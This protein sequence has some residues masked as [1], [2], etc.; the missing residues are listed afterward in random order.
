MRVRYVSPWYPDYAAIHSGVFVAK[1]VE[2]V[3]QAGHEVTVQVPQIFPAPS[4]PIPQPVIDA[5]RTLAGDSLDAMFSSQN[6]VTYVPSPV[7]SRG[8]PLGRA[9]AVADSLS[10][11]AEFVGD[12]PDVIHAHVGLPTGLAVSQVETDRPL[13][14]TEHWSGLASALD[15]PTVASAYADLLKRADA[16]ICVSNHL[17]DQICEA[18]G[19]WAGDQIEVIPNIVDLADITFRSRPNVDFGSW[20]Y[21]GGLMQHKGV[22][23][24]VRAFDRYSKQFDSDARLTL[25]GD[26]PM[27]DWIEMYAISHGLS[28]SIALTGSV[29]HSALGTHLD[30]ADVMVHLSP[31]ETFGIASLEGIGAGLPVVSLRNQGA[32]GA[33]G[34]LEEQ[35]GSLLDLESTPTDVAEAIAALKESPD[36][37][38]IAAGRKMIEENF[39]PD[40]VAQ[41]L[42]SIY[43]RV[44]R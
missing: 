6:Q 22:Q 33:W 21:I 17:K 24:L 12:K 7:P 29:E 38:D 37:L 31:V 13:V 20:I 11:L 34:H 4:G 5:M 18:V 32:E 9:Q 42:I 27:R 36:R 8:G 41:Q 19:E 14:V 15:D 35:C 10:L 43:Q 1:Q 26:G 16:F 30:S 39:S 28:E 25:L 3:R 23:T 2:A 44:I 40:I